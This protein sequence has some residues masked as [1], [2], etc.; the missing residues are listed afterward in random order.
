M[1]Y[2]IESPSIILEYLPHG[3]LKSFLKVA[4][5]TLKIQQFHIIILSIQHA[6]SVGKTTASKEIAEVH[7]RRSHGNGLHFKDGT[8]A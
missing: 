2:Y 3:D 8:S 5:Y 4:I 7:A 6:H 1:L